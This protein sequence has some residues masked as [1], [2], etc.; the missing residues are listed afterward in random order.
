MP[1]AIL[2]SAWTDWFLCTR[3]AMFTWAIEPTP[4]RM[5]DIDEVPQL[6]AVADGEGKPLQEDRLPAYSPLSGCTRLASSG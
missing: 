5:V 2:P 6:D 4:C 1:K 3:R